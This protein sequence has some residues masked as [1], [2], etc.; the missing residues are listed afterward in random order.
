MTRSAS[1]RVTAYAR[2][3]RARPAGRAR[4]APARAGRRSPRRSRSRSRSACGSRSR[5]DVRRLADARPRAR[6]RGGRG[7][8]S[9]SIVARDGRRAARAACSSLPDG[10]EVVEG[11][12]RAPSLRLGGE[13]ERKLELRLRC[14]RWGTY[15]LGDIRLR[16]R[17]RLGLLVWEARARRP[18]RCASTRARSRCARSS[19]PLR[20]AAV[21]RATRSR[22]Q[23]GDGLEF[24]DLRPFAPGDRLRSINWRASA[25]RDAARRQRAPPRAEHRRDPLPRQL[26]RG[27]RAAAR[28]TLD[29]A[30]RATAT[31]ASRYLERRDRVGLVTFGGILRWLTPGMGLTQ[32]YRIVDALLET[33]VELNYAWKDVD[34]PGARR[35]R[36][37]RSCSRSRRSSTS[38]RSR[39]LLDLRARG[40]DL[41]VLEISPEPYAQPGRRAS[42]TGSRTASGC[43]TARA[44]RALRAARCRGCALARRAAA[45][46]RAGGGEHIPAPRS[47]RARLAPA[48]ASVLAR[49]GGA[50]A[51]WPSQ[52]SRERV[53]RER[54]SR[55]R[56]CSSCSPA[57]CCCGSPAAVPVGLA[58][59]GAEYAACSP[60]SARAL[61][62]RAPFVAAAL[63]VVGRARVLVARAARADRRRGGLPPTPARVPALLALAALAW[64]PSARARGRRPHRRRGGRAARRRGR[65]GA[66]ALLALAARRTGP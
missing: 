5:R 51:G 24:A 52:R 50:R 1:P 2:A 53:A 29:L 36:R 32:R 61:D 6:A 49:R 60:S 44:A 46:G 3:R 59:L 28:S 15:P 54:R 47:P 58:L 22:A 7:R 43:C 9:S 14:A 26:R 20:D 31:L 37:R 38:A 11:D 48:T 25:R 12:D 10:L 30:V 41:A 4:S 21:H 33:G 16:A 63:F 40:Y 39:A 64:A 17:D 45:R 42:S 65:G 35:C 19:R 27:P 13:D 62:P 56:S 34:H 57:A 8:A 66:V 23:K 18:P 55:R